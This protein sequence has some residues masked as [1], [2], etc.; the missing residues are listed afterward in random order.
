MKFGFKFFTEPITDAR[1]AVAWAM[2][3]GGQSITEFLGVWVA[4]E[5]RPCTYQQI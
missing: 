1:S 2:L 5:M 3:S 4:P